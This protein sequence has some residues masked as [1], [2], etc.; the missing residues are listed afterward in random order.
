MY[1]FNLFIIF[2]INE[3]KTIFPKS[4]VSRSSCTLILWRKW[5]CVHG[6]TWDAGFWWVDMITFNLPLPV[7]KFWSDTTIW[8]WIRNYHDVHKERRKK[9][10]LWSNWTT[11]IDP[12]VEIILDALQCERGRGKRSSWKPEQ[13]L[14]VTWPLSHRINTHFGSNCVITAYNWSG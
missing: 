3:K 4:K 9:K 14:R 13:G 1:K 11:M 2:C 8:W 7:A 5:S 6:N 12:R 10:P